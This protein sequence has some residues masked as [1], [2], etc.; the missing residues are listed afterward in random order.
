MMRRRCLC[1]EPREGH[2]AS[3]NS[4]SKCPGAGRGLLGQEGL[5][6]R[7]SP[8]RLLKQSEEEKDSYKMRAC[9][10]G[11][12]QGCYLLLLNQETPPPINRIY[13]VETWA[14][15]QLPNAPASFQDK[16]WGSLRVCCLLKCPTY[17]R[18]ANLEAGWRGREGACPWAKK[19]PLQRESLESLSK[20]DSQ[21][22]IL[23]PMVKSR[24]VPCS[25]PPSFSQC[26]QGKEVPANHGDSLPVIYGP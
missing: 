18:N 19:R 4:K 3:E 9:E 6:G 16:Y 13:R 17:L 15:G 8:G 22:E 23:K 24:P 21:L 11:N 10:L 5:S 14:L 25:A 20:E 1:E 7:V 26:S 2:S 12:V